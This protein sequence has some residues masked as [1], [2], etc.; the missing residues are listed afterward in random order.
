MSPEKP[1]LF[2]TPCLCNALRRASR[3]ASR[4]YDEELRGVGLRTT[5]YSLLSLLHRSGEVRQGDLGP[6]AVLDETTLT[7]TL[8]PLMDRHWVAVREGRD[9]RERLVSITEAGRAKLAQARPAWQRA[10]E[11][12]RSSLPKG[13]WENLMGI[14]P[15]VAQCTAEA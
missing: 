13:A 6:R 10:Q 4:L 1:T 3:A 2:A 8:R 5:Q 11:R 14:L 7:R 12:M 9:R 15:E